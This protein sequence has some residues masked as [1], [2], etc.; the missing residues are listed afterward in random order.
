MKSYSRSRKS[1]AFSLTTGEVFTISILPLGS[2]CLFPRG[3]SILAG[4]NFILF[5][6]LTLYPDMTEAEFK[7]IIN[8]QWVIF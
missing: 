5:E 8:N 3:L 6:N 1:G 7:V 4:R 2:C